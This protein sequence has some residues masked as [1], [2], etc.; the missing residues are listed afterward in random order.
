MAEPDAKHK[1]WPYS[2]LYKEIELANGRKR[3][4]DARQSELRAAMASLIEEYDDLWEATLPGC[5]RALGMRESWKSDGQNYMRWVQSYDQAM[6]MADEYVL[7]EMRPRAREV[8]LVTSWA[9]DNW[10]KYQ[11]G[12][13]LFPD[14]I[15]KKP[16]FPRPTAA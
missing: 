10:D 12:E 3:V 6:S 14:S 9:W 15:P 5:M 16:D 13:W 2:A 11:R 4:S 1:N 7:E 8:R